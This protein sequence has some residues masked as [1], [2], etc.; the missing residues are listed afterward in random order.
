MAHALTHSLTH[1]ITIW[2]LITR[3]NFLSVWFVNQT[4]SQSKKRSWYWRLTGHRRLNFFFNL[5][6]CDFYMKLLAEA[7]LNV[8][9]YSHNVSHSQYRLVIFICLTQYYLCERYL[10][11]LL[12]ILTMYHIPNNA[13]L[14]FLHFPPCFWRRWI[15]IIHHQ[16]EGHVWLCNM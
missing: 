4:T 13:N 11:M 2:L 8:T 15:W 14:F 12:Y 9:L 6:F 1:S 3:F 7:L 5:T 10:W 16:P